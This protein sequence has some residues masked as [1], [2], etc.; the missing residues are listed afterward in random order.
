MKIT[1]NLD[2][3]YLIHPALTAL[4]LDFLNSIG[5]SIHDVHVLFFSSLPFFYLTAL[6]KQFFRYWLGTGWVIFRH[7]GIPRCSEPSSKAE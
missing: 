2:R 5:D 6:L 4:L 7:Q 1:M 3:A